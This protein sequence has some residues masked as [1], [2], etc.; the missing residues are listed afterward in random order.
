MTDAV[1]TETQS[2]VTAVDAERKPVPPPESSEAS[3][4]APHPQ[5]ALLPEA[6]FAP[7]MG[8]NIIVLENVREQAE[9]NLTHYLA[10]KLIT[11]LKAHGQSEEMIIKLFEQAHVSFFGE[12]SPVHGKTDVKISV[13][14]PN[15]GANEALVGELLVEALHEHPLYAELFTQDHPPH[16]QKVPGQEHSMIQI[17]IPEMETASY[18]QLVQAMAALGMAPAATTPIQEARKDTPVAHQ[19]GCACNQCH[20]AANDNA[21]ETTPVAEAEVSAVPAQ[22]PEVVLT[23]VA[24]HEP[25]TKVKALG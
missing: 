12:L 11:A 17:H 22:Q 14:G 4:A 2:E 19:D 21:Q 10:P 15:I 24:K 16:A 18:A 13:T 1:T 9:Q 3:K 5:P 25:P 7:A 20:V 23:E 6:I 8:N